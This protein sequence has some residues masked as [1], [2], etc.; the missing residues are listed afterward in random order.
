MKK[1]NKTSK[2]SIGT[3]YDLN[4]AA[5]IKEISLTGDKLEEKKPAIINFLKD[6]NNT[7]YMLLCNERKDY[8]IFRLK[9]ENS[10]ND[11][12]NCLVDECLLNRGLVKGIDITEDQGAIEIWL[13][14]E[15]EAFVYYFFPYDSAIV[16]I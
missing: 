2:V 12:V 10:I 11:L 4:K 9:E 7:Y 8:T 13:S 14:I 3:L 15:E 6:K 1:N 5:V 16:E